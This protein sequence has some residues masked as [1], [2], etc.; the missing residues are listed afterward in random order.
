M[1]KRRSARL[2]PSVDLEGSSSKR[3]KGNDDIGLDSKARSTKPS[4][5]GKSSSPGKQTKSSARPASKSSA[6][7]RTGSKALT[8]T[9]K[10]VTS[11]ANYL[12][13]LDGIAPPIE[14][15]L[16]EGK[17]GI[18][19]NDEEKTADLGDDEV[20]EILDSEDDGKDDR[21]DVEEEEE[22]EEEDDE[23]FLSDNDFLQDNNLEDNMDI[24][25][26][27]KP[28]R[29]K[30][31]QSRTDASASVSAS[32]SSRV[33]GKILETDFENV[34]LARLAKSSVRLAI[35]VDDM[36]PQGD[37]PS[38]KL[39]RQ[40]LGKLRNR[41]MLIS[42]KILT[43]SEEEKDK[44]IKFMNY[45]AS[46]VRFDLAV[47][48]RLLV[49]EYYQLS[50]GKGQPGPEEVSDLAI[51]SKKVSRETQRRSK[52]L[53]KSSGV[54]VTKN[55]PPPPLINCFPPPAAHHY[56]R[57]PPP[58]AAHHDV[59]MPPPPAAHHY[60]CMPPPPAAHH[61]ACMPPPP[62]AHHDALTPPAAQHDAITPPTNKERTMEKEPM[63]FSSPLIGKILRAH[64]VDS[65][66]YPDKFLLK[67]F[68][69]T[70]QIPPGLIVLIA[71]LIG[72]A[73]SEWTGGY[74]TSIFLTRGNME[75]TYRRLMTTMTTALKESPEYVKMLSKS[76]YKEMRSRDFDDNDVGPK[77]NFAQL[78]AFGEAELKRMEAE[79]GDE[80]DD[81]EDDDDDDDDD[82]GG[83]QSDVEKFLN[84]VGGDSKGSSKISKAGKGGVSRS[85]KGKGKGKERER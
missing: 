69:T 85:S 35:C 79:A 11:K 25:D 71:A 39:L 15:A 37:K 52:L 50:G 47:P 82:D 66:S 53:N 43:Q 41:D 55:A 29:K 33:K 62:A 59:R 49:A 23:H 22:E 70:K 4:K 5:V 48:T 84:D 6:Q 42:L 76:L 83:L 54:L 61:D 3:R 57:M 73:I 18:V 77:Y 38:L 1:S 14:E 30:K 36:W 51:A 45:A 40:E 8:K 26:V 46:Q 72:H 27:T 16:E 80:D 68:K 13:T 2:D 31:I 9:Q 78:Q 74:R 19:L 24:E 10:P 21:R 28:I 44:L 81:D 56:V 64:F 65:A 34:Q 20:L 7:T 12:D 75:P 63:P 67:R 32:A 58:P 60:A 17:K